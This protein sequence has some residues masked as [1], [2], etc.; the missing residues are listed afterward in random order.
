MTSGAFRAF[1]KVMVPVK[2]R[3]QPSFT[4]VLASSAEPE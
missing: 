1:L 2:D 4:R 3:C